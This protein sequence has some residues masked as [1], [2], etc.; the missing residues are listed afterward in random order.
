LTFSLVAIHCGCEEKVVRRY[1]S[2][3]PLV[4]KE[5][6]SLKLIYQT[7]KYLPGISLPSHVFISPNILRL[8]FTFFVLVLRKLV[9][10][11]CAIY[12]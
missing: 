11:D 4:Q 9:L 7:D 6:G 1:A 10:K 5:T 3:H 12:K 2:S 8:L